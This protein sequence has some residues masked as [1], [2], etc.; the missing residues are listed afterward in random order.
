MLMK[1]LGY[2]QYSSDFGSDWQFA[3]VKQANK[4][5]LFDDVD[6]GV[7]EAMTRNDL[8]QLVLNTLRSGFFGAG[9]RSSKEK[10]LADMQAY[11][12]ACKKGAVCE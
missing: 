1:A 7:R 11:K 4:I 12:D 8:A 5:D 9:R 10:Q 2:F 6:S 3:T